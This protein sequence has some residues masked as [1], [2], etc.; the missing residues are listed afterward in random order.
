MMCNN[1][2][3]Q[4]CIYIH[5]DFPR[6]QTGGW[7]VVAPSVAVSTN[8]HWSYRQRLIARRASLWFTKHVI[9]DETKQ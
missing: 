9:Y 2:K 6:V 4:Y 5:M 8:N 7:P 1:P 3:V